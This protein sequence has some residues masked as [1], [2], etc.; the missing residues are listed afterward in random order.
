MGQRIAEALKRSPFLR[1]T[2]LNFTL[3]GTCALVSDGILT[4]AIS[5][6]RTC[7]RFLKRPTALHQIQYFFAG[8]PPRVQLAGLLPQ[9]SLQSRGCRFR[10]RF[11]TLMVTQ[12]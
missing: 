5:S 8:R 10:S 4:P 7:W 6:A 3:L 11:W 2:L 1:A 12:L 9:L